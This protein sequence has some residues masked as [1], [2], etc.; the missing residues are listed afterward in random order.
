LVS[1]RAFCQVAGGAILANTGLFSQVREAIARNTTE[2]SFSSGKS[3]RDPFNEVE[4]DVVFEGPG[5]VQHRVPAF[6]AGGQNW[7]VRY[8]A[9][10]PGEYTFHSVCS[11]AANADLHGKRGTLHVSP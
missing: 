10:A 8:A 11:D 9:A 2:W 5:G 7:R 4:L 3:Y 6:W 1:R